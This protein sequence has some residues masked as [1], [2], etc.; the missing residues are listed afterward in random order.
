MS[1]T[2]RDDVTNTSLHSSFI[3]GRY[4]SHVLLLLSIGDISC[5]NSCGIVISGA[6]NA[7][8]GVGCGVGGVGGGGRDGSG[9]SNIVL[10]TVIRNMRLPGC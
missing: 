1:R 4:M 2:Y 7:S 8:G 6:G 10:I 3:L 9:S 5:G